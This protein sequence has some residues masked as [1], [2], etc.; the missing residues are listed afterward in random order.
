MFEKIYLLSRNFN[1]FASGKT[2]LQ[3]LM[4]HCDIDP[5][6]VG[7]LLG[8]GVQGETWDYVDD[9]VIKIQVK[10]SEDVPSVVED[11]NFIKNN[12]PEAY[13]Q[14]YHAQ[15]ICDISDEDINIG[16]KSGTAYYYIM[17]KLLPLNSEKAKVIS[18]ILKL[19]DR[20]KEIS[21]ELANSP[22]LNEAEE[23]FKKL[24]NSNT[25]HLDINPGNIMQTP[26]GELKMVDLDS[27][28]VIHN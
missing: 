2:L 11:L 10:N 5:Q 12:S 24:K 20:G 17:D 28:M 16:L 25:L 8:T 14:I 9:T 21:E 27:V 18:K 13:P 19:K 3:A 26:S 1:K 7:S 15:I 22:Y 6:G 23:L 4:E